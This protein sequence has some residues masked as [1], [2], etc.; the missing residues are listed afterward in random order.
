MKASGFLVESTIMTLLVSVLL[1]LFQILTSMCT[2][3]DNT[4]SGYDKIGVD[5][6]KLIQHIEMFY[7]RGW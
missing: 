4:E 3:D 1:L 2:A 6:V 5:I 7:E